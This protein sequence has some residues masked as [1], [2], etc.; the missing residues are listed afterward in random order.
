MVKD[1]PRG[2]H[3]KGDAM[4]TE[5]WCDEFVL[6]PANQVPKED[7]IEHCLQRWIGFLP[8]NLAKHQVSYRDASSEGWCSLCF[9]WHCWGCKVC[10]CV[11]LTGKKCGAYGGPLDSLYQEFDPGPGI[12]LLEIM[13]LEGTEGGR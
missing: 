13:L 11:I 3:F 10:P 12:M 1:A 5:S 4:S 8:E 7:A 2:T 9:H 6:V